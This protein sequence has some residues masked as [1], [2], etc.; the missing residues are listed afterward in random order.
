[1]TQRVHDN[2]AQ[3]RHSLVE[4]HSREPGR[5]FAYRGVGSH[6]FGLVA[7]LDRRYANEDD[8][9]RRRLAERLA[10]EF[11]G[12]AVPMGLSRGLDLPDLLAVAQHHGLPTRLLDWTWSPYIAA[13]FAFSSFMR[14]S[15]DPATGD[16]RTA[17]A[18][19]R[20]DVTHHLAEAERDIAVPDVQVRVARPEL[21]PRLHAQQGLFTVNHRGGNLADVVPDASLLQ[22]VVPSTEAPVALADLELMGLHDAALFPDLTGAALAATARAGRDLVPG[23]TP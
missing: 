21:T 7:S 3:L 1:M 8:A 16:R 4:D 17:V 13:Y 19:W 2:W 12:F 14:S 6:T 5:R 22:A 15:H 23:R 20:L 9:T 18:V 10:T 11:E